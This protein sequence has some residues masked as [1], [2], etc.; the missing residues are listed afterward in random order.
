MQSQ[1]TS[2]R[3]PVAIVGAGPV[4]LSLALGLARQGVRSVLIERNERTSEQSKAPGI[5]ARTR[6]IFR[7]WGI[8]DRFL[9]AG[10]LLPDVSVYSNRSR[11]LATMDFSILDN[12]VDRPGLL[13][14]EQAR[15]EKLLLDALRETGLC[16]VR[17][18]TEAIGLEQDAASI[19]LKCREESTRDV[20]TIQADFAIGCDGAGSFTRQAL[21]LSFDGFT[22]SV[23]PML[24]DIRIN[25]SRD[26]L[27]WPRIWNGRGGLTAALRLEPG[28]W[29]LI[30]LERGEPDA[31]ESVPDSEIEGHVRRTLGAGPFEIEWSSRFRI[32]LRS[33]STFRMG[34][35][36][37]AGDAAHIHSPAGGLGM[38]AGIQ[39]AHNLAWK[40]AAALAGGDMERLL[41][42]YDLER[43][44]VTVQDVSRYA[45]YATKI[46]LQ[47]PAPLKPIAFALFRFILAVPPLCRRILRRLTMI[48]LSYEQ[49]PLHAPGSKAAGQ[50]LPNVLVQ[51]EHGDLV[52]L[53]D[54]VPN[55]AFILMLTNE[56]VTAPSLGAV[57]VIRIGEGAYGD[58]SELA[59]LAGRRKG[60]ILVRPDLYIGA[61]GSDWDACQPAWAR[62]FGVRE[63]VKL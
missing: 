59:K 12:E 24:A 35:V 3:I 40:L 44:S 8:E 56:P 33:A 6:E 4:G 62:M 55:S 10:N 38:N 18:S 14:L 39:D 34:R 31:D 2:D 32:H 19:R 9:A 7:Q 30:R 60:W 57:P 37:L 58:R 48:D 20:V 16:D 22:Y 27:P 63:Q 29:R 54:L 51:T 26:D 17:F 43:R 11:R 21:G 61:D 15:T 41:A 5:H 23:Q 42:S 49:S 53:Y 50:R 36:L 52:R 46:F 45:D 1:S 25:D 13:I 28:M 47:S